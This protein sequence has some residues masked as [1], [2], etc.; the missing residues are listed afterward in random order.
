MAG[1]PE[2]NQQ[3]F[4]LL[5]F[6]AAE[7]NGTTLPRFTTAAEYTAFFNWLWDVDTTTANATVS[8][9]PTA[10]ST[11]NAGINAV[12][13]AWNKTNNG[14]TYLA[15]LIKS[16]ITQRKFGMVVKLPPTATSTVIPVVGGYN[17]SLVG[18]VPT[19]AT[20][21]TVSFPAFKTPNYGVPVGTYWGTMGTVLAGATTLNTGDRIPE[22]R[23]VWLVMG[24]TGTDLADPTAGATNFTRLTTAQTNYTMV[25]DVVY[26][27]Y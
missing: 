11:V 9:N 19:P 25:S 18:G 2:Q 16:R 7:D 24:T 20:N 15:R 6:M 4:L 22:G 10:N 27:W 5:S 8:T 12:A 23:K 17:H 26:E 13:T 3:R 14:R 1:P 21:P